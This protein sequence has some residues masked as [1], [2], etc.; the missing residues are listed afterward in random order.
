MRVDGIICWNSHT[1]PGDFVHLDHTMSDQP[2]LV[3]KM[4]GWHTRDMIIA[5]SIFFDSV[6]GHSLNHLNI[7]TSG[8]EIYG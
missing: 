1:A 5:I 6:S 8:E 7:S 4:D 3:P 2:G